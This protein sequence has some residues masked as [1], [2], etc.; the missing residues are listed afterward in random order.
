MAR[1]AG[2]NFRFWNVDR[3]SSAHP[4]QLPLVLAALA[5]LATA[6]HAHPDDTARHLANAVL[7]K[8][9]LPVL[10]AS[11]SLY[12]LPDNIVALVAAT[13]SVYCVH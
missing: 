5:D 6:L 7:A 10:A 4:A 1:E 11:A 13:P 9:L 2:G 8:D 3:W 12:A